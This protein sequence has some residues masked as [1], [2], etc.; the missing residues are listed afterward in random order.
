MSS[1][2]WK[3]LS[4]P[5][6]HSMKTRSFAVGGKAGNPLTLPFWALEEHDNK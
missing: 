5:V 3:N 1:G 4:Y 2:P 6:L